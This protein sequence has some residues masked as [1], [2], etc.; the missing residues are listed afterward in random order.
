MEAYQR[1]KAEKPDLAGERDPL[2]YGKATEV[3]EEGVDRMV[4]ELNERAAKRQEYSRRRAARADADVDFINSRNAHFNKKLE[5][6]VRAGPLPPRSDVI[7]LVKPSVP[8]AVNRCP[9]VA[10][11]SCCAAPVNSSRNAHFKVLQQ[12]VLAPN[13]AVPNSLGGAWRHR[14]C[15]HAAQARGHAKICKETHIHTL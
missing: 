11:C 15:R 5:R 9:L 1:T 14:L 12:A 13:P 10:C 8:Q 4:A 6:C 3:G 2:E 7:K